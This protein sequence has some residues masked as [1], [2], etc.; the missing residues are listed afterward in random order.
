MKR[1]VSLILALLL[2]LG[3]VCLPGCGM[4]AV[5]EKASVSCPEGSPEPQV[6]N[7]P[8]PKREKKPSPE[9]TEQIIG[10]Q[11]IQLPEPEPSLPLQ[12]EIDP[13]KPM[14]A[15]SFDDG[16]YSKVTDRIL[17]TLA[18]YGA[19]A[20]FFVVGDRVAN[21]A[22]T[23]RRAVAE[24]HEIG[25]HTWDHSNLTSLNKADIRRQIQATYQVVLD[26][27]GYQCAVVRPPGG[28]CSQRVRDVVGAEGLYLA[29][30][31]VD[32]QD[33]RSRDAQ[34]VYEEIM[35]AVK[36]GAIILC[37]DLYP[38]TAEAMERVV[39]DLMAQGYQIVSVSELLHY[40]QGTAEAGKLYRHG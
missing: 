21:Y 31:S 16:P 34:C 26:T 4:K 25:I 11:P 30:W 5:K 18:Q 22:S 19:H 35:S 24:G 36:D 17:D 13:E 27:A 15:L 10:P 3:W 1:S 9:Q 39:P 32:S 14:V 38:S 8:F 2:L 29:N 12:G 20:T 37:H 7:R 28:C 23:L 40:K 33:W 6:P